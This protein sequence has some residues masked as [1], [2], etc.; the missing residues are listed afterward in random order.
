MQPPPAAD[1]SIPA[2]FTHLIPQVSSY[3]KMFSGLEL[4]HQVLLSLVDQAY[5]GPHALEAV[6]HGTGLA[7]ER[8]VEPHSSLPTVSGMYAWGALMLI[9]LVE[10]RIGSCWLSPA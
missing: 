9:P 1:A 2:R 4:Q 10:R 7:W 6:Q 5:H 8:V 3:G